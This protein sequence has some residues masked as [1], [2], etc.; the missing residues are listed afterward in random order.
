MRL[1]LIN[2]VFSKWFTPV[3]RQVGE[4]SLFR[5]ASRGLRRTPLTSHRTIPDTL[6]TR[7][8]KGG[9]HDYF[10]IRS[11]RLLLYINRYK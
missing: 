8:F 4:E 2:I 3:L 9:V 1:V 11:I 6:F 7:I 5:F 10:I